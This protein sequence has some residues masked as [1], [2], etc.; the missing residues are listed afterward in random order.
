MEFTVGTKLKELG[1]FMDFWCFTLSRP[2]IACLAF[3]IRN[4]YGPK[5]HT[6][7]TGSIFLGFIDI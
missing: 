1:R 7:G 6:I 5:T 4:L 3:R 2:A